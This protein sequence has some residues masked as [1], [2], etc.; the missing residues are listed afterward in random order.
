MTVDVRVPALDEADELTVL[1]YEFAPAV[2]RYLASLGSRAPVSTLAG[3]RGWNEAHS[4]V[5]LK[6]GQSHV[7][8]AL[9]VDHAATRSDYEQAR[10]RDRRAATEG[11]LGALDPDVEALVFAG[12]EGCTWAAR[13]GWPSVVIPAGYSIADRRPVG[14]MLV[15]RPWTDARLLELAHAFEQAHP[16]RRPPWEINPAAFR[17]L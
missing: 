15:S 6:F 13:A 17:Y 11:L 16:V 5:A 8:A 10:E 14:I 12:A 2:D 4:E 9:A 3:L 1:H 7:D